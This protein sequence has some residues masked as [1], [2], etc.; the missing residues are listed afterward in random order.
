[1]LLTELSP[2]LSHV[3]ITLYFELLKFLDVTPSDLHK[4]FLQ[5]LNLIVGLLFPNPENCI[6][7]LLRKLLK[8]MAE[9]AL[10]VVE[11][12][13]LESL[14]QT[15]QFS[16]FQVEGFSLADQFFLEGEVILFGLVNDNRTHRS[17]RQTVKLGLT[18]GRLG[19]NFPQFCL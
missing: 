6:F 5:R 4:L 11:L 2:R 12:V 15:C 1:M 17:I 10:H 16:L 13:G 7:L 18:S 3:N 9:L 19:L 8:I 14:L